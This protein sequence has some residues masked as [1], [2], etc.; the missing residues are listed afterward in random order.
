MPDYVWIL[1]LVVCTAVIGVIMFRDPRSH[2]RSITF[3]SAP[4]RLKLPSMLLMVAVTI[5][6]KT[7][8]HWIL[9]RDIRWLLALSSGI[10]FTTSWAVMWYVVGPRWLGVRPDKQ[11]DPQK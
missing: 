4:A 3:A 7:G 5:L 2:D 10:V 9:Y 1:A 8:A 11:T 6:A